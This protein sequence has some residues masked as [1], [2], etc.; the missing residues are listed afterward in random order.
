MVLTQNASNKATPTVETQTPTTNNTAAAPSDVFLAQLKP[1]LSNESLKALDDPKSTQ[2]QSLRWLVNSNFQD[3]VF[4]RQV[5]RYMP[6]PQSS[7][8]QYWTEMVQ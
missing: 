4:E 5:Q 6:W 7:M 1:L 2:S 8:P 3:Y